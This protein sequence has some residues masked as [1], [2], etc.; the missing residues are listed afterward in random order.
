MTV[1]DATASGVP[2]PVI[3]VG[4]QE[5]RTLD[6]FAGDVEVVIVKS[7]LESTVRGVGALTDGAVRFHEKAEGS[8]K[9]VRV[10]LIAHGPDGSFVAATV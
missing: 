8:G 1:A 4:G 6:Q 2:Y 9:D 7:G 3:A 10:W 5:P